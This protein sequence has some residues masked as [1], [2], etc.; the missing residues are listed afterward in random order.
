MGVG[1]EVSK[2]VGPWKVVWFLV[3]LRPE[4]L[5]TLRDGRNFACSWASGPCH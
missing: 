2:V 1:F 3:E 5:E 4:A